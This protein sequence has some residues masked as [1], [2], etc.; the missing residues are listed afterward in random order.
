MNLV[1]LKW[2]SAMLF[3]SAVCSLFLCCV[4]VYMFILG[5][6]VFCWVELCCLLLEVLCLVWL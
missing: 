4:G 6:N 5:E 1:F 2:P 3:G